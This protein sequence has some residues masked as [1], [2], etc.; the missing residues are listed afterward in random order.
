MCII[1]SIKIAFQVSTIGT[2]NHEKRTRTKEEKLQGTET[3]ET[4]KKMGAQV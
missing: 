4:M 3:D 2:A 1:V